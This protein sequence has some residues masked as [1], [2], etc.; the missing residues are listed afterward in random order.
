MLGFPRETEP[1]GYIEIYKR[2]FIRGI[3][4]CNYGGQQVLWSASCRLENQESSGVIHSESKAPRTRSTDVPGQKEMAVTAQR[5]QICS[6]SAF[7]L[8]SGPQRIG[9]CPCTLVR[10]SSLI[11]L[12][13]NANF[14]WKRPHRHSEITFYQLSGHPLAQSSWCIKS[15][16]TTHKCSGIFECPLLW[17]LLYPLVQYPVLSRSY[18]IRGDEKQP[19]PTWETEGPAPGPS[20]T[21]NVY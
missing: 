18:L 15:T 5:K 6:P 19:I 21:R 20:P 17:P 10:A 14:F 16:I 8:H 12:G 11:S 2:G 7:L 9:W 3:N 13:L 1:K 4:S